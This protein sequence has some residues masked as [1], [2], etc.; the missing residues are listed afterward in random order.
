MISH[1]TPEQLHGYAKGNLEE[2]ELTQISDHLDSCQ[3]CQQTLNQ[4]DANSDTLLASLR[5]DPGNDLYAEDAE[6][7]ELIQRLENEP[8]QVFAAVRKSIGEGGQQENELPDL[9]SRDYEV[10]RRIQRGGMGDVFLARHVRLGRLVALKLMRPERSE[11]KESIQ[12]F[13]REMKAVGGLSHRNIVQAFDAGEIQGQHFLAMELVE[14]MDLAALQ[15]KKSRI[16]IADACEIARQAAA[17]LEHAFS[18]GMVHRDIKPSNLMLT[19]TGVVKLLDLGLARLRPEAGALV[20]STLPTEATSNVDESLVSAPLCNHPNTS[21]TMEGQIMGTLEYMA[22]EQCSNTR[23]VDVRADIY[24]LGATLYRLLTG[25][26][27]C[28]TS[29][30]QNLRDRVATIL[31][32][33]IPEITTLRSDVPRPLGDIIHRMLA[34][35]PEDRFSTPTEVVLALK[36]WTRGADLKKLAESISHARNPEGEL[37][38]AEPVS[39]PLLSPA[40][41]RSRPLVQP[42]WILAPLLALFCIGIGLVGANRFE[43]PSM[44]ASASQ[45]KLQAAGVLAED[46]SNAPSTEPAVHQPEQTPPARP[47]IRAGRDY[48]AIIAVKDL[49]LSEGTVPA[50][51]KPERTEYRRDQAFREL[52]PYAVVEGES[53]EV[54]IDHPP[55]SF[56]SASEF[57]NCRIAIGLDAPR[58]CQGI[59]YLPNAKGDMLTPVR[60]RVDAKQFSADSSNSFLRIKRDYYQRLI[61]D[62]LP[63]SNWF[64]HQRDLANEELKERPVDEV[65]IPS[66]SGQVPS[67][68]ESRIDQTMDFISGSNAIGE[69]LN[70]GDI[71]QLRPENDTFVL[72]EKLPGVTLREFNWSGYTLEERA[73][74]QLAYFIPE[75]Q[76]AIFFPSFSSVVEAVDRLRKEGESILWWMEG[77]A[78]DS[79]TQRLYERQLGLPLGLL[80][81]KF[82][83]QFVDQI[84][85]TGGDLYFR[86]G[87]DV[88]IL[89]APKDLEA[90][91][92]LLAAQRALSASE[93]SGVQRVE[94]VIEE[95]SYQ[96]FVDDSRSI[97]NYQATV[98]EVI[99]VT[100][101]LNQLRRIIEVHAKR[102][103]RLADLK[104]YRA[105]RHR[106]PQGV[107]NETAFIHVSDP[108]L[109]RWASARWRIGTSRRTIETNKLAALN[110]NL[111]HWRSMGAEPTREELQEA[112]RPLSQEYVVEADGVR[113]QI[114]GNA[115]FLTPIGELDL[116]QVTQSEAISYERWLRT[117]QGKWTR[118][119]DPVSIQVRFEG[120]SFQSDVSVVPLTRNS[121]YSLLRDL[122]QGSSLNASHIQ[123]TPGSMG[124]MAFA[125]NGKSRTIQSL[126]SIAL[127]ARGESSLYQAFFPTMVLQFHEDPLWGE[128]ARREEA[129]E[130]LFDDSFE[131]PATVQ[132]MIRD[133]AKTLILLA[134]LRRF[135]EDVGGDLLRWSTVEHLGKTYTKVEIRDWARRKEAGN[136]RALLH[137]GIL[138]DRLVFSFSDRV[139]KSLI[140]RQVE[141]KESSGEPKELL[142][143]SVDFDLSERFF[144]SVGPLY[145]RQNELQMRF[146]AWR[147]LPILNELKRQ[148]PNQDPVSVYEKYWRRSLLATESGRFRWDAEN[149]TM[150]D[151][152]LGS[153]ARIRQFDGMNAPWTNLRRLKGGMTF[154][155]D[156]LRAKVQLYFRQ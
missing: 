20:E 44:K 82:G 145:D 117:Y 40:Q 18:H 115:E 152:L 114:Y 13:L 75:D 37:S 32:H 9:S 122:T 96:G 95:V 56:A 33:E 38:N 127:P 26:A 107:E 85:L 1:P 99:V 41:T 67:N 93:G 139:F 43:S 31:R 50:Y 52:R 76:H 78:E 148:F 87:T 128:M 61:D 66:P 7:L 42:S 51:T 39:S 72:T 125:L 11:D 131:V 45:V 138:E 35:K 21:L 143:E 111:I 104:E 69:N 113:H 48:A 36:P 3:A 14:G 141:L 123:A 120:K 130:Y 126:L 154:Q 22:P 137:Y 54:Y 6:L 55:M 98:G 136:Y 65:G 102:L 60:F 86:S 74:D 10:L 89:F 62:R 142:G 59:L 92:S 109:R 2:V 73:L 19:Q 27:P 116:Q 118:F 147:N 71:E 140:E 103:P 100:N 17:G 24:G 12:R 88:A 8:P 34:E 46:D 132:F 5:Q 23:A 64:R 150:E 144:Q 135:T 149:Q 151:S 105:M 4:L 156:S 134:A 79:G 58:D 63:G 81:R 108:T 101:S 110:A 53:N 91:S 119:F 15:E 121:E 129:D 57:L 90:L 155:D 25:R 28:I 49:Q 16:E 77:R 29:R 84:A 106:Y 153:P 97:C 133:S 30:N 146:L 70:L 94:G 83:T 80:A 47:S 68:A 124:H 112:D